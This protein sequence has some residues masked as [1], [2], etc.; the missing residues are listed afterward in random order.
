[1]TWVRNSRLDL[2]SVHLVGEVPAE[3]LLPV[4]LEEIKEGFFNA[5]TTHTLVTNAQYQQLPEKL[6]CFIWRSRNMYLCIVVEVADIFVVWNLYCLS[7]CCKNSQHNRPHDNAAYSYV[8]DDYWWFHNC[9]QDYLY[10]TMSENNWTFQYHLIIKSS[11]VSYSI[12]QR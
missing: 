12:H 4:V 7:Y 2:L 6:W 9:Y 5:F 8:I 10:S 11:F 1:M 3:L